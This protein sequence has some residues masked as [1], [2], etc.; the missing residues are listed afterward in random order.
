MGI[1]VGNVIQAKVGT[2]ARTN[3]TSKQLF[4]LPANAMIIGVRAFG[5]NSDS[6]TSATITFET[7]PINSTTK[8]TFATINAK[9]TAAGADDAA[10]MAGAA[11]VRQ[12]T[13]VFV[14]ALYSESGAASVGGDWNLVVEYL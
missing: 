13:P 7:Q 4:T 6:L 1:K 10:T 3:T 9:T 12:S 5:P 2:L 14:N 11:Y 8:T